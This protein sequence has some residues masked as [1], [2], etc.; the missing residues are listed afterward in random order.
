MFMYPIIPISIWGFRLRR[1]PLRLRRGPYEGKGI[2]VRWTSGTF[3]SSDLM[4]ASLQRRTTKKH[5]SFAA[6]PFPSWSIGESNVCIFKDAKNPG[7]T[8]IN[9]VLAMF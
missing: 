7:K 3:L 4:Q 8:A 6:M 5:R 9:I 1:H 2:E